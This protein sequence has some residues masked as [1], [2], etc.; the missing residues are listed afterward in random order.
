MLI[1]VYCVKLYEGVNIFYDG[2]G[3]LRKNVAWVMEREFTCD[4]KAFIILTWI[5][6]GNSFL[7]F[8]PFYNDQATIGCVR[9]VPRLPHQETELIRGVI[10]IHVCAALCFLNCIVGVKQKWL[11]WRSYFCSSEYGQWY[12]VPYIIR[13]VL[14]T[15]NVLAYSMHFFCSLFKIILLV[16]TLSIRMLELLVIEEC[17]GGIYVECVRDWGI[18]LNPSFDWMSESKASKRKIPQCYSKYFF[19]H[20]SH[21]SC[22]SSILRVMYQNIFK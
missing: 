5:P 18:A 21:L 22:V 4:G 20:F 6:M 13:F 2:P 19:F 17:T 11:N 15:S 10:N 1:A 12:Y 7:F 9:S 14:K 8:F 16:Q 3:I